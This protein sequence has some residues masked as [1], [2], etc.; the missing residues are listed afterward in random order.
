MRIEW[1][2]RQVCGECGV[3]FLVADTALWAWCR[4]CGHMVA[5]VDYRGNLADNERLVFDGDGFLTL[6]SLV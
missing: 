6:Q 1:E 5:E 2:A 4:E 3:G